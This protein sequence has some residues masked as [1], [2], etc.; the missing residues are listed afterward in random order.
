A[1]RHPTHG[2]QADLHPLL[3]VL[4]SQPPLPSCLV[5]ALVAMASIVSAVTPP[6]PTPTSG[7]RAAHQGGILEG[8]NPAHYDDKNP[9]IVFIIQAGIIIVFC[10]LLQYPLSKI[11]QPTVIAEIIGGIL[12]GPS[13]LG[14]IPGF[15]DAI[16]PEESLPTLSLAANLG[17][18][19]FLF[20]VG[21]EVDLRLLQKN[22]KISLSVGAAGMAIPFGLGCAV[23]YGLYHEFREDSGL[24]PIDFGTY[25]LFVGVAMAITAFPVL[26]RI[27]TELK[28][29]GSEVG[30][31]V[32]SAGVGNDVVGWIL[33]ALCVA[34][35]NAGSGI[36]AL[37]V[38]LTAVAYVLFLVY[39]VRPIFLRILRKSGS[40]QNGPTQSMVAL[41]ILLVFASAFFTGIIG[42]HPIFGAFLVGLICPHDGGF[43]IK[44]TEK[45]EDLVAVFFLPLY[46]A[47]SGLSTNIGLL[48]SGITWA[49]V[50]AV[51]VIAFVGKFVGGSIAARLCKMVWRESFTVG[52]LMSCKGLVELIV[53]NIGLQAKILS[54]RTF[55]IFV[56]MALVTTFATTPLTTAFYPPWYQKKLAAWKRGEI[57]WDGNTL[58]QDTQSVNSDTNAPDKDD[59]SDVRR[60]L[61][62]LRLESLPSLF[63]FISLLGGERPESS[64]NRLHPSK[65]VA[66]SEKNNDETWTS[67]K[68]RPLQVHG[69]RMLEL[70]ERLSSVMKESEIEDVSTR[71]PVVNSFHSFGQLNNLST[72]GDV[73]I[74]PEGSY[75]HTLAHSAS[76]QCTD[77]VL[78]PWSESGSLSETATTTV[79]HS[80]HRMF[81]NGPHTLFLASFLHHAPCHAAIFVNS[82]ITS[83]AQKEQEPPL[84]RMRSRHSL[85]STHGVSSMSPA[86]RTHHIFFPFFGGVD[87]R[88]ALRFVLRLAGKP[89]VTATILFVDTEHLR[90]ST[91]AEV[92]PAQS[93]SAANHGAV[94]GA[95]T[96]IPANPEQEKTFFA[97]MKDSLPSALETRVVFD[98]MTTSMRPLHD[99]YHR[100]KAE[101]GQTPKSS[102]DLIVLGRN[103]SIANDFKTETQ[104][105]LEEVGQMCHPGSDVGNVL[106]DVANA[107]VAT[108]VRASL[109]VV[110][111]RGE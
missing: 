87:D 2:Q 66:N 50:V 14:R 100:A 85:R 77:M 86:P 62:Y 10:R 105:L 61:V 21:L 92:V 107:F 81:D 69:L 96:S 56:V 4:T 74:V 83:L 25:M 29:L 28:L 15:T 53:L 26:C 37:Y 73:E 48:D 75:A 103:G 18:V 90:E 42:V 71:D 97:S 6:S 27:L 1:R 36:V 54:T 111:G 30:L 78:L 108:G 3:S 88:V 19:L 24:V 9:I 67:I 8:A 99:I 58:G 98:T 102:G 20:L 47:L 72:S 104:V 11:R 33:L 57:D 68:K 95:A 76:E 45:I 59:A 93:S 12:L 41:T 51:I 55:T 80:R 94:K 39:A 34:L 63:T 17:L 70:T 79:E 22:W 35:V 64:V 46:F 101:V 91:T 84:S 7:V 49:Y 65:V 16:F 40:I 106:G 110:K 13:V 44:L 31:V 60:L 82:N 109:L 38:L 23:A 43:A 52:V 5:H 89:N 32:L